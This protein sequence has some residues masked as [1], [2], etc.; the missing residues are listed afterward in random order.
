MNKPK[1]GDTREMFLH[2][3]MTKGVFMFDTKDGEEIELSAQMHVLAEI[4]QEFD[5]EDWIEVER[6]G[7][8]DYFYLTDYEEGYR[9]DEEQICEM[10]DT[11]YPDY[12]WNGYSNDWCDIEETDT[13]EQALEKWEVYKNKFPLLTS[14]EQFDIL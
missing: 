9:F 5:G 12:E 4:I 2:E 14:K 6:I 10:F 13:K 11:E 1:E 8:E 3:I 7:E